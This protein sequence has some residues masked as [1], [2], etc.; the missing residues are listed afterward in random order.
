MKGHDKYV[1]RLLHGRDLQHGCG[2]LYVTVSK[3]KPTKY[4]V[5]FR[6]AKRFFTDDTLPEELKWKLGMLYARN[7]YM[8][9]VGG[10]LV[11]KFDGRRWFFV[12][13][14]EKLC[15]I[16]MNDPRSKSQGEGKEDTD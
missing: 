13:G 12:L 11:D 3:D 9:Y 10:K 5:D 7:K 16:L 14:S 8:P 4:T 2:G 1:P 6:S 15:T